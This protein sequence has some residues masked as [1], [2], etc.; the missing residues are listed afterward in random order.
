[1]LRTST[2]DDNGIWHQV[3][4]ALNEI[5]TDWWNAFQRAAGCRNI[6]LLRSAGTKI[7]EELWERLFAWSKKDR[8]RMSAG[9]FGQGSHMQ[10]AEADKC[11]TFSIMVCELVGAV[12]I[13]DVD[14]DH[15]QIRR[16]VDSER[17]YVL[18]L[19]DSMVIRGQIRSKGRESQRREQRV[20]DRSPVRI[21]RLSQR[22]ENELRF[23]RT[24]AGRNHGASPAA[25]VPS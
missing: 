22:G 1:M 9:F 4:P 18:V 25:E 10:S 16:V 15:H 20:L 14:L 3:Q 8:V 7:F 24:T 13:G 19:D 11:S 23:Q 21:G 12:R 2:C 5:A 6:N 17:L